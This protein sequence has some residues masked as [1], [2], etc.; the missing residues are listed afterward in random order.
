MS[1]DLDK[2]QTSALARVCGRLVK[3]LYCRSVAM[4]QCK[5]RLFAGNLYLTIFRRH[6]GRSV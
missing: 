1:S 2:S 6:M 4:T 3:D 5:Q